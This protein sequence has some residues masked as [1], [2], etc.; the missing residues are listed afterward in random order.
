MAKKLKMTLPIQDGN[1]TKNLKAFG[2]HRKEMWNANNEPCGIWEWFNDA[3]KKKN[4]KKSCIHI[5]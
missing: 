2:E 5:R 3:Q 4:K 1:W